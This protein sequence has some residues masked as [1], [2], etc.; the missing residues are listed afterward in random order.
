MGY[1]LR[2]DDKWIGVHGAKNLMLAFANGL[3]VN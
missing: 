2:K 1:V 3:E